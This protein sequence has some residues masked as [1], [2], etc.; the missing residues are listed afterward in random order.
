[1]S[2]AA[3]IS[4]KKARKVLPRVRGAP[5]GGFF[6]RR[7]R[8]VP[9]AFRIPLRSDALLASP[10][11]KPP[12]LPS[13]LLFFFFLFFPPRIA[14]DQPSVQIVIHLDRFPFRDSNFNS[15]GSTW[16]QNFPQSMNSWFFFLLIQSY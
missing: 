2:Q 10:F 8:S 16:T 15:R 14:K 7:S 9:L 12:P 3:T 1:M 6:V 5:L 4:G 13:P 11:Q